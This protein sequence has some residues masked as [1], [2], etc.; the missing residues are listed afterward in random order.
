[1]LRRGAPASCR[2]CRPHHLVAVSRDG[3]DIDIEEAFEAVGAAH[4]ASARAG[5]GLGGALGGGLGGADV[6]AKL[7]EMLGQKKSRAYYRIHAGRAAVGNPASALTANRRPAIFQ[8][9]EALV[10]LRE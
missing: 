4:A 10:T 5:G 2:S 1:M 3:R 7:A 6:S 9:R 8:F